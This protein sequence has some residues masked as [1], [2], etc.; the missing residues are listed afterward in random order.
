METLKQ[1]QWKYDAEDSVANR[2]KVDEKFYDA[3]H[4]FLKLVQPAKSSGM[5]TVSGKVKIK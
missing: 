3:D 2:K 4:K 5:I 1:W